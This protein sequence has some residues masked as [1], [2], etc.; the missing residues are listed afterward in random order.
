MCL[1]IFRK[2]QSIKQIEEISIDIFSKEFK[3]NCYDYYPNFYHLDDF[4]YFKDSDCY[5]VFKYDVVKS[6]LANSEDYSAKVNSSFDPVLL[7]IDGDSHSRK[8]KQLFKS[9]YVVDDYRILNE[10]AFYDSIFTN[11]ISSTETFDSFNIVDKVVNPFILSGLFYEFGFNRI[12]FDID[13][14]NETVDMNTLCELVKNIFQNIGALDNVILENIEPESLSAFSKHILEM[15]NGENELN[16]FK[17]LFYSGS[18]TTSS[19]ICSTLF[20]LYSDEAILKN[21]L[22]KEDYIDSL[23]NEVLRLY[24]P[25]QFT[26]RVTTK[27]IS[28]GNQMIKEGSK[29]AVSIGAANRDPSVFENPN[30]FCSERA[31]SNISF[32]FGRHKCVGEKLSI[33]FAKSFFERFKSH[34]KDFELDSSPEYDNSFVLLI[35]KLVLN[36]KN[37][38]DGNM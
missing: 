18:E 29:I 4:I 25:A 38:I 13:L 33:K 27:P 19:L 5:A 24:S 32:G 21:F 14:L 3:Q 1:R 10:T 2:R 36:R 11:L 9:I 23:L 7:G 34:I 30:Q 31:E 15:I 28:C 35:S 6:I 17:F 16:F 12:P 20:Q 8:K 37:K 26:F 22:L